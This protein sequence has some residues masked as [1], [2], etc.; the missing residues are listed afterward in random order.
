MY[1]YEDHGEERVLSVWDGKPLR[2]LLRWGKIHFML[3]DKCHAKNR[4]A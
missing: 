1:G 2:R 4:T 3:G